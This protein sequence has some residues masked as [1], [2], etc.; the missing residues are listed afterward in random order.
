MGS[1]DCWKSWRVGKDARETEAE[2]IKVEAKDLGLQYQ[3]WWSS[4]AFL[5][6]ATTLR[7]SWEA[8]WKS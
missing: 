8:T 7:M 3:I 4:K 5:D 1:R 2:L 6:V